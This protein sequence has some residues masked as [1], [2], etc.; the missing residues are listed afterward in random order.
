MSSGTHITIRIVSR[1]TKYFLWAP[2]VIV[3]PCI[4]VRNVRASADIWAFTHPEREV[5]PSVFS[6]KTQQV[7]C[8]SLAAPQR[9]QCHG[10]YLLP[11]SS[12]GRAGRWGVAKRQWAEPQRHHTRSDVKRQRFL[13]P[14]LVSLL[15]ILTQS[16]WDLCDVSGSIAWKWLYWHD[17]WNLSR[18]GANSVP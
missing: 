9:M 6:L 1:V 5:C 11:L 17:K 15:L 18:W 4:P 14:P 3:F 8:W 10:F 12:Q 2:Q 7:W 16:L 13:L